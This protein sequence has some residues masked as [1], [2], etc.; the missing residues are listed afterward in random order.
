MYNVIIIILI[1]IIGDTMTIFI[2]NE[3]D[4]SLGIEY[5]AIA[6]KVV[7]AS[8]DYLHCPYECEINILLTDNAGIKETNRQTR[9]IDQPTDVLSFPAIDFIKPGDFSIVENESDIYFNNDTGELMLGDIMISLEKVIEQAESYGHSVTREYAFLI[10]H[11]MLHLS[12]FDHIDDDER[13]KMEDMQ[14]E[15][16]RSIGYTRDK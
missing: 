6:D 15:I 1:R 8:L 4:I 5:E 7:N 2:D 11:S 14:E 3:M 13:Q 10:A 12:G 9:N 16:L